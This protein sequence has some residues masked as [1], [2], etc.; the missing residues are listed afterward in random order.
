MVFVR[1]MREFELLGV[2]GLFVF[3]FV[4]DGFFKVIGIVLC[5]DGGSNVDYWYLEFYWG[6]RF[7][8]GRRIVR[9]FRFV[10]E[11]DRFEE[12]VM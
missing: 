4:Y 5:I 6:E 1:I 3:Y 7:S 9:E 8:M 11:E 10:E 12:V 2:I